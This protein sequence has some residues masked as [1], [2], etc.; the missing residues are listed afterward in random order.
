MFI[1]RILASLGLLGAVAV[2]GG[3][4]WMPANGP[5]GDAVVAGQQ[6]PTSIPYALVKV[7]PEAER[8]LAYNAPRLG[9]LF[10]DTRPP[11]GLTL[12]VKALLWVTNLEPP[13]GGPLTP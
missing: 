3:C 13:R 5:S 2:V 9:R 1:Y 10:R 11:K 12:G 7:T 6:D 4:A 8:V